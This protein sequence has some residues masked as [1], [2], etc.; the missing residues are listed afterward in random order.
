MLGIVRGVSDAMQDERILDPKTE[1][2]HGTDESILQC[3]Y[4]LRN[5][6]ETT[7]NET[8]SQRVISRRLKFD[9]KCD[10]LEM[11]FSSGFNCYKQTFTEIKINS[12]REA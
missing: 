3:K 5:I 10:R 9:L 7:S 1:P 6:D 11:N 4:R 2:V 8:P 12:E